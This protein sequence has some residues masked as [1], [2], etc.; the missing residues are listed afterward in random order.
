M[1]ARN[2]LLALLA[3][4]LAVPLLRAEA[5]EATCG[6]AALL[7][8]DPFWLRP[9][10]PGGVFGV[11]PNGPFLLDVQR[12]YIFASKKTANVVPDEQ[13]PVERNNLRL[14]LITVP[15]VFIA[16]EGAPLANIGYRGLN[17]ARSLFL[18]LRK[19]NIPIAADIFAYPE[20]YY[21]PALP[22]VGRIEFVDGGSALL[23]GPAPGG[24]LN[25]VTRQPVPDRAIALEAQNTLGSFNYFATFEGLSGTVGPVGYD[26]H[27]FHQE[28]DGFRT[29]NSRSDLNSGGAKFIFDL[30]PTARIIFGADL[31]SEGHGEPGGLTFDTFRVN[32][33]VATRR[34]DF[35]QRRQ[36]AAD[37]TYQQVLA[38]GCLLETT[39]WAIYASRFSRRQDPGGAP[40]FGGAPQGTTSAFVYQEFFNIAIQPRFRWDYDLLG[41]DEP[42]TFTAGLMY[43]HVDVPREDAIGPATAHYGSTIT[44]ESDR[45]VNYV[46]LFAEN[47]F[48][49]GPVF[50][51]PGLRLENIWQAV[52]HNVGPL[53]QRHA[54]ENVLLLELGGVYKLAPTVEFYSNFAQSYRP[55]IFSEAVVAEANSVAPADLEPGRAW[56]VD[57]GFRGRPVPYLRWDTS[58]FYLDYQDQ[59]GSVT[60]PGGVVVIRNVG[61]ARYR[62]WEVGG[63]VDLL[64]LSD[65]LFAARAGS[66]FGSLGVFCNST[67]LD[68]EFYRGPLIGRTPAYAPDYIVRGGV[69]YTL[70]RDDPCGG[71][72]DLLR[73]WL[74][75]TFVGDSFGQDDNASRALIPPYRVWDLTGEAALWGNNLRIFG[76]VYNLLND[77][78]FSRVLG[79]GID[80]ALPRNFFG[81]VKLLW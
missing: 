81:G 10:R 62:G 73:V 17:A 2:A 33:D 66:R 27:A 25:F 49:L 26:V 37:V 67:L 58:L 52:E 18:V 63:Q 6:E 15:G 75:G 57:I 60:G 53:L 54:S 72:R 50:I 31:F 70:R 21:F 35:F 36:Y 44:A 19:D 38:E 65:E 48:R 13:P 69:A 40:G 24:S 4:V 20:A 16:E 78:Y 68:A 42:S 29:F 74:T 64:G 30:G 12:S 11:E 3:L 79:T 77:R 43:Y 71:P 51:V 41:Q 14:E 39:A 76:G 45:H 55:L 61:D 8:S 5:D 23:Y 47:V 7:Q 22:T 28:T 1:Q 59:I 56:Q 9:F 34:Y 46:P 80:P 32:P